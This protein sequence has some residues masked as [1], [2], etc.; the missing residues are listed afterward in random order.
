[1]VP[2]SVHVFQ[3]ARAV[4]LKPSFL[5]CTLFMPPLSLFSVSEFRIP[6]LRG[7]WQSS[8]LI[9]SARVLFRESGRHGNAAFPFL[10]I[11]A[12][13]IAGLLRIRLTETPHRPPPE[14]KSKKNAADSFQSK[15]YK[16]QNKAE[17]LKI[18]T[19][20]NINIF[21]FHNVLQK[22]NTC[23]PYFQTGRQKKT[24]IFSHFPFR[25]KQWIGS[26]KEEEKKSD[27]E[28]CFRPEE[29]P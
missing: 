11:A 26:G 12:G 9:A 4:K 10:R 25:K 28:S 27:A 8:S 7:E 6:N 5:S 24:I 3:S 20:N 29:L 22:N 13:S 21:L 15:N 17:K 16:N 19:K 23:F 2:S 18:K 14:K 1:M